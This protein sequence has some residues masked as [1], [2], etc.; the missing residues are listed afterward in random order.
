MSI[1]GGNLSGHR[2]LTG[3]GP[4]QSQGR[5]ANQRQSSMLAMERSTLSTL[6]DP[7]PLFGRDSSPPP[8]RPL[9]LEPPRVQVATIE[10]IA[11]GPTLGLPPPD[12]IKKTKEAQSHVLDKH[13]QEGA[14]ALVSTIKQKTDYL[15]ALAKQQRHQF[16]LML[17]QQVNE[18]EMALLREYNQQL[19]QLQQSAQARK[20]ELDQSSAF[21]AME[22]QQR[23]VREE[24]TRQKLSI[25]GDYCVAQGQIAEEIERLGVKAEV[26]PVPLLTGPG[27]YTPLPGLGSPFPMT[28]NLFGGSLARSGSDSLAYLPPRMQRSP[29]RPGSF[30]PPQLLGA[31]APQATLAGAYAAPLPVPAFPAEIPT[32]KRAYVPP[33]LG[34]I[35]PRHSYTAPPCLSPSPR[36]SF[37]ASPVG[38]YAPP[39]GAWLPGSH[40]AAPVG[41]QVPPPSALLPGSRNPS[42]VPP[43]VRTSSPGPAIRTSSPAPAIRQIS[44]GPRAE[45]PAG[46]RRPGGPGKLAPAVQRRVSQGPGVERRVSMPTPALAAPVAPATLGLK[47]ARPLERAPSDVPPNAVGGVMRYVPPS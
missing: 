9:D 20:A 14:D 27:S 5:G 7:G 15:H 34:K 45:V 4:A 3:K 41:S 44:T 25:E 1:V 11:A 16:N 35:T 46:M 21:L 28:G 37:V 13:V 17:D 23:K 40:V 38:S 18:Q 30:V 31:Q 47:P 6:E 29:S 22:W 19:M 8:R 43:V 10:D 24:F 39:P 26:P 2:P 36:G 42:L 33:A 32:G 12:V